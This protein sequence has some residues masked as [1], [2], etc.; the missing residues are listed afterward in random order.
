MTSKQTILIIA[1]LIS[2]LMS[3]GQKKDPIDKFLEDCMNKP[4]SETTAGS[5]SCVG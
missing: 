5:V 2:C 3:F 4:E 1:L